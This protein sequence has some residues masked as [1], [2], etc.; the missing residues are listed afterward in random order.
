MPCAP[1]LQRMAPFSSLS[2]GIGLT[3]F[4]LYN[5]YVIPFPMST[6][7]TVLPGDSSVSLFFS[8]SFFMVSSSTPVH[9][10]QASGPSHTPL[11]LSRWSGLQIYR[12]TLSTLDKESERL[13]ESSL[14]FSFH[15]LLL[16]KLT[17]SYPFQFCVFTLS[18]S[19]APYFYN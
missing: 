16:G 15:V 5:T 9:F 14:Q 6:G 17:L 1:L 13:L 11:L 7:P 8:F 19:P 3:S 18:L 4:L 2:L 12:K 10:V